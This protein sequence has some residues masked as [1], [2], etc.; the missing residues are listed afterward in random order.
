MSTPL[1]TSTTR[2]ESIAGA[3]HERK[4]EVRRL[5]ILGA[6]GSIGA[7]TLSIVAHHPG[8]FDVVALTGGSNVELLARQAIEH[9]AE[10]AV[11]AD[12]G[13]Y[14][15]LRSLLAGT[16][17]EAAAGDA[18]VVEAAT[19]PADCVMASIVGAA[20][21]KPTFAALGQGRRV[22]LANKECLVCA[23]R[24]FMQEAKRRHTELLPV[25]SEH[26]ALFQA[27]VGSSQK[28]IEHMTLTASGGPFRS[29]PIEKIMTATPEMA[30]DHPNWRMG[31]K[32]T[33]DSATMMN[34]GLELIE[35]Q[36]LFSV[37]PDQL[38][39]VVHPQ[40]IVHSM[41][42]FKDGSVIAQMSE[43]DMRIP[44]SLALA[45]PNRISTP[46]KELNLAQIS[47]L[48]FETPDSRR[49]PA[50][51]VARRAL[52]H[53]GVAPTVLNAANEIAVSAFLKRKLGV[54]DIAKV[55]EATLDTAE[56]EGLTGDIE[57]VADALMI[58]AEARRLASAQLSPIC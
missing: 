44:I 40:S 6:S 16:G 15:R 52:E 31:A 10:I 45:W 4:P 46:A 36:H 23:G 14:E 56:T 42:A 30:L 21:L 12:D 41:V 38:R 55:V 58:D 28:T 49:F 26:S 47:E 35:A 8:R 18:A 11:V 24:A 19:R 29:W 57:S 9:R 50:L 43:P 32:V 22:A 33:I 53:G 13:C 25:D 20:G 7:N 2:V 3:D 37:A 5:S 27:L 17:I 54:L 51:A 34:K 39:V 48:T 1:E